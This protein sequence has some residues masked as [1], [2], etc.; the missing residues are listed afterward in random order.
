MSIFRK[1]RTDTGLARRVR[2]RHLLPLAV[3]MLVP[4]FLAP[5]GSAKPTP[6]INFGICVQNATTLAPSCSGADTNSGFAGAT[7]APGA[8]VQV[9]ITNAGS[10]TAAIGTAKIDLPSGLR[11]DP[12]VTPQP[13]KYVT[14]TNSGEIQVSG[15]QIQAGKSLVVTFAIDTGCDG[16][17][18][19][20]SATA[21]PSSGSG[22]FSS[23]AAL[24]VGEKSDLSVGCHLRFVAQPTDTKVG[25]TITDKGASTGGAIKVELDQGDSG[26]TP[27]TT[28]PFGAGNCEVKVDDAPG[29][30]N[31]SES[32]TVD[33]TFTASFSDL[34]IT[35]PDVATP[36]TFTLTAIGDL[37][38]THTSVPSNSFLITL[39]AD[40]CLQHQNGCSFL[41]KQLPGSDTPSF[42]SL[43]GGTT[44][45]FMTLSPYSL[46]ENS[47]PKGCQNR[48]D[49]HVAGFAETDG[50]N[51]KG[52]MTITYFV[53]M[54]NIKAKYGANVGQQFIAMCVGAKPVKNNV[55]VDCGTLESTPAN[56][57]G[58]GGSTYGWVGDSLTDQKFDGG[59]AN[60]VCEA[61]GF[62][63]GI[64][65]SYQDKIPNAADNPVVTGWNGQNIGGHNYRAF[66]MSIPDNWD[67]RGGP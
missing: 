45:N 21:L 50:R 65:S 6:V 24:S 29:T 2:A 20:W 54:D 33:N 56:L 26:T 55:A 22:S 27:V 61:D 13:S 42:A 31:F 10:S 8:P 5:A 15:T 16:S 41:K 12:G 32:N 11:V 14:A 36:A 9:T 49:L 62:Y 4:I 37:G 47:L 1:A 67:Y 38:L 17:N 53:N 28:C 19:A 23:Q 57:T 43:V 40:D 3:L 51:A 25:S 35:V 60:A 48:P 30:P 59:T 63:W 7:G 34:N 39:Y 52:T 44:F 18:L 64:I 46:D 66:T 58:V